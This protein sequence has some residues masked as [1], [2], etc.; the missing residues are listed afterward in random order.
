MAIT[1]KTTKLNKDEQRYQQ[2][3]LDSNDYSLFDVYE[4]VSR[5]KWEAWEHCEAVCREHEGWD[6]KVISHNG[7]RFAAGF[8]FE[9]PETG[10]ISLYI[11]TKSR[12]FAFEEWFNTVE[13]V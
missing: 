10:A 6:L 1:I 5:K 2:K 13:E 7:Y 8:E 9:N 4:S 3:Y 11:I 12:E